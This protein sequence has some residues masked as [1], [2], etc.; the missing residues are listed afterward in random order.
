MELLREESYGSPSVIAAFVSVAA[1][2]SLALFTENIIDHFTG[3]NGGNDVH[4]TIVNR[5]P[6]Y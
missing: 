1:V 6:L 2:H 3:T 5:G 4:V